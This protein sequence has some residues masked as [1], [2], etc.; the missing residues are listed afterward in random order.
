MLELKP[1]EAV[2]LIGTSQNVVQILFQQG[3]QKA[4]VK[5]RVDPGWIVEY[6]EKPHSMPKYIFFDLDDEPNMEEFVLNLA[7]HQDEFDQEL[8]LYRWGIQKPV[9]ADTET[10][11]AF[12]I[13]LTDKTTGALS[14][15]SEKGR[16]LM[17]QS[18]QDAQELMMSITNSKSNQVA[19]II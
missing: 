9:P 2:N 18:F 5:R 12:R 7:S 10:F 17:I 4:L 13:L 14:W 3:N 6:Y 15:L 19:I 8:E 1:K 16:V 11:G